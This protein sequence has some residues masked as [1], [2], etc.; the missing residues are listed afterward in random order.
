MRIRPKSEIITPEYL[1]AFLNT[2]Y[3][4]T[5]IKR[6][7]RSSINQS[8]V[9]PEELKKVEI[10]LLSRKLQEKIIFLFDE[11]FNL[12]QKS[13]L[14]YNKAQSLLLSELGLIGWKPKHQLSFV[15]QYSDVEKSG[16]IDAEYFQPKYEEIIKK[17]KDYKG[18]W[19]KLKN[20]V[21]LKDNNFHPKENVL[22]KY[23]ELS[24]IARNGE[25]TN[26]I[27]EEGQF[28]PSRAKRTV[29][30]GDVIV[31]SVEGSLSKIALIDQDYDQA[32]CS[33]GFYVINSNILNSTTILLLMKSIVG[34]LQ[35]KKSCGGMILSSINKNKFQEI[36]L[37]IVTKK[38]QDKI[39]GIVFESLNLYKKS[40]TL[41]EYS[42]YAIEK[43][44]E[45][46]EK[47]AIHWLKNK[48]SK[49][50]H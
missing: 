13:E 20:L 23:I 21:A 44:I 17:I 28:L 32:I 11:A 38:I 1:T 6:R 27:T 24:H 22:Y 45:K 2:K 16:R 3:G 50:S 12:L 9:N 40:K 39:Q 25:I 31:S 42:K 18:G 43:A 33:N 19:K 35:L 41:L 5:D 47:T 14:K 36:T 49:A 4:I 30:T 8:N 10:P 46:D 48:L 29:S 34:Q 37:P 7:A 15:K 26:C